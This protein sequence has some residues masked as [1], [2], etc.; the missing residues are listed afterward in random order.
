MDEESKMTL[1][2]RQEMSKELDRIK[3]VIRKQSYKDQAG[4]V[5]HCA[6]MCSN[7]ADDISQR[8]LVNLARMP[9]K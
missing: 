7:H 9:D 5:G 3:R 1:M 6:V 2:R 8:D 4:C